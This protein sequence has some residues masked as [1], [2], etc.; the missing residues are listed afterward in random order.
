MKNQDGSTPLDL[1]RSEEKQDVVSFLSGP[2]DQSITELRDL[3]KE[4]EDLPRERKS[5]G[6]FIVD[7]NI[8]IINRDLAILNLR[9]VIKLFNRYPKVIDWSG[10]YRKTF[11][12]GGSISR[13]YPELKDAMACASEDGIWLDND[14]FSLSLEEFRRMCL[15]GQRERMA[16]DGVRRN[17]LTHA[18]A[19]EFQAVRHEFGHAFEFLFRYAMAERNEK[20]EDRTVYC[21]EFKTF[22]L[23]FAKYEGWDETAPKMTEYGLTDDME[24]FAESFANA[25]NPLADEPFEEDPGVTREENER[26]KKMMNEARLVGRFA[27][28]KASDFGYYSALKPSPH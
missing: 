9:E 2:L 13:D 21:R 27:L 12:F 7:D 18:N 20:Y 4:F 16:R 26:Q 14:S 19:W 6:N 28:S 10:K 3:I 8:W 24:W 1:A 5:C 17:W 15:R 11:T 22:L 25:Q 23:D